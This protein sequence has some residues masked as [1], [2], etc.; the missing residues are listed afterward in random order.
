MEGAPHQCD[1]RRAD[2]RVPS[3]SDG[4]LTSF[5]GSFD[6]DLWGDLSHAA[7]RLDRDW[8]ESS[9]PGDE[10]TKHALDE[11]NASG[12]AMLSHTKLHDEYVMRVS[13][14]ATRTLLEHV[15]RL[16]QNLRSMG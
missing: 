15:Q 3:P 16:F 14:G 11:I 13:I 5:D 4:G 6:A 1:A 10:R 7:G 12:E 8:R 2:P 9:Y